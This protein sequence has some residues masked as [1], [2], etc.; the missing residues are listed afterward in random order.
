MCVGIVG[1]IDFQVFYPQND[2]LQTGGIIADFRM[3]NM[4]V[5]YH[6]IIGTNGLAVV[7]YVYLTVSADCKKQFCAGVCVGHGA[8]CAV[9]PYGTDIE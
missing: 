8:M 3:Y 5:K 2:A 1:A 6:H 9:K 7:S 4:G